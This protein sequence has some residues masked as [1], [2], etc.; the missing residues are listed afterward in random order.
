MSDQATF[1]GPILWQPT[2]DRVERAHLTSF[3]RQHGIENFDEL[4][5]RSV[6][7][8]AWF[9]ASLLEYLGIKF[10]TPYTD[11]LDMSQGPAWPRWCVGGQMNIIESCLDRW[12]DAGRGDAVSLIWEGEDGRTKSLSYLQLWREVNK[13]ANGLRSLGYSVGDCI[14]IF[15]PM[16][17]E[18]AIVLLAIAKIGGIALPLFSGYGATAIRTR[19]KDARA[20]GLV[21][22][23][24]FHR[25]G[26]AVA[27]KA[28][29]DEAIE[30][31]DHIKHVIVCRYL[32]TEIN[33]VSE[34]DLWFKALI[35]GKADQAESA[36]LD[37]E[38]PLMILYT[39]GT[40]GSPKGVVHTHCG[41]PVKAAQDMAFGTDVHAGD[42]IY[43]MTDMGW[44]MGPWL[45][46]GALILGAKAV[47]YDGAPDFPDHERIWSICDRHEVNVL[48]V[49]PTLIRTLMPQGATFVRRYD[50]S[51]IKCFASTGEP[52]NPGPWR[53]LYEEVGDSHIPIINYSGGT[54]VSG[55][56]LMGNPITPLKACAFSAPCPGIWADVF[57]EAGNSLRGEVG[58]LVIKAPWI[59]MTRGF[60]NDTE[61]YLQTYWSRWEDVWVHGDF[62]LIDED[63]SWF[64]LGRSD[65][66]LKVA[67]KRIGPAEIESILVQQEGVIEAA[68]IGIPDDVKGNS[69]IGFCVL[70]PSY[71]G[72]EGLIPRLTEQIA[73]NMGKPLTPKAIFFVPDLPK[74]RNAKVMRR[75]L[76][77]VYLGRSPGDTSALVNPDTLEAIA[78]LREAG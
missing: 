31:L 22:A 34:R 19:L 36:V 73:R 32:Q 43:W 9:T 74:T 16:T 49:S 5:Q 7:E 25:R 71:E 20:R 35:K 45:I 41:F 66:T 47:V 46:F 18:I 38:T 14:G 64:I 40:T 59:G 26:K 62:A 63:G 39:S 24:G 57:D 6:T 55:G 75:V 23:D 2:P 28:I 10:S 15:M 30:G 12:I 44:M 76:R 52:W 48:G 69:L 50:L 11:V 27:M 68:V 17:L 77:D 29:A 51:S 33:M 37:S 13:V 3:M 4:H 61:R 67:G 65:D 42:V 54:E 1:G 60:L 21:T 56:I 72:D 78:R 53:W 70:E 58:E 8:I